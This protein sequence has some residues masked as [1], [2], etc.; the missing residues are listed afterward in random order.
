MFAYGRLVQ[1]RASTAARSRATESR[2]QSTDAAAVAAR[3]I[4]DERARLGGQAL[5]LLRD[6]VEGMRSDAAAAK[7][8]LDADLIESIA[9]RGRQAVTELRW[10]LGLLRSTPA[11]APA[12]RPRR[13]TRWIVDAGTAAALVALGVLE[14]ANSPVAPT[15]LAWAVAVALPACTVARERWPAPALRSAAVVVGFAVIGNLPL[16]ASGVLCVLLLA[17]SAGVVGRLVPW[18]CFAVLTAATITW[19]ALS[20]PEN[21]TF[22]V[23]LIAVTVVRRIRVVGAGPRCPGRLGPSR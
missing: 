12:A 23:A 18:V 6:A 19:V 22:T 20:S 17:W 2:L 11:P 14:A 8:D 9:V 5:G 1:H 4:A 13:R 15:A 21:V 16:I 3:I 7:R 10:L